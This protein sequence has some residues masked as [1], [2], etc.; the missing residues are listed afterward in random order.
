MYKLDI[1]V[2]AKESAAVERR[3]IVEQ[4]R[5]SRIFNARERIIGLD[6]RSLEK[7]VH[8]NKQKKEEE[9][10]RDTLFASEM[11]RCDKIGEL[12]EERQSKDRK[13]QNKRLVEFRKEN[14]RMEDRREYDIND[15][16]FVRKGIP[17]R[18]SDNDPRLT[19]SGMQKFT[20]EDLEYERRKK[21]QQKQLQDWTAEQSAEKEQL[22]KEEAYAQHLYQLKACQMDRRAMEL[23]EAEAQTRRALNTATKDYNLALAKEKEAQDQHDKMQEEDDNLTEMANNVHGDLLSENPAVAESAFG[24]HR[25]IPDRWKG[26]SPQQVQEVLETRERQAQENEAAQTAERL[27]NE[28]WDRQRVA[29]ARA[30]LILEV[31]EMKKK[32]QLRMNLKDENKML[33]KEQNAEQYRLDTEV[34]VNP[35]AP[36]FFTQFNTTS[37]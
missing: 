3:R 37:R 28:E 4:Q 34:Y 17:A 12:M 35:P 25:V 24:S 13:E 26:M 8:E 2:D 30:A 36:S 23:A 32:K 22:N 14:Q 29:D 7:Q 31:Q 33:A 21:L 6:T 15:P 11:K 5:R 1:Q 16:H 9:E 19:L 27:R 18:V 10:L 20:G